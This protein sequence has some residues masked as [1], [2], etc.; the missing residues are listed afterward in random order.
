[1]VVLSAMPTQSRQLAAIMFTDIVGYTALMQQNEEKAIQ[2]RE[3][4]RRI[5]NSITEKHKGRILQYY[6]DGTLSIFDSAID[7]VKCGI[8]LQLGFQED[9]VIPVRIGI[10]TGDIIFSEEEIIGDGVNIASRIESL[11]VPGS[12][13]ISDKVYD[14]IKNQVSI[15]TSMLSA[16]K[17]KNVEKPV[18]VY[19]ISNVGLVVPSPDDIEGKVSAESTSIFEKEIPLRKKGQSKIL[20][21]IFVVIAIVMVIITYQKFGDKKNRDEDNLDKSIAVLPIKSL[22]D[23]PEKQYLAD[24]VMDAITTHLAKIRELR[25]IA[26]TSLERYKDQAKDVRDIGQELNVNFL[27]EG[28]FQ[29]YGDDAMLTVQLINTNDGSHIWSNEYE[30]EWKDIFAVQSEVAQAIAKKIKVIITPGIKQEIESI[31]TSDL[32]AYDYYLRGNEYLQ[33]SYDQQDYRYAIQMYQRATEID[34]KFTLA[35]VGLAAASRFIY[36][37]YYDRSEEQLLRIKKY[38]DKAL[39]LSPQSKEVLLEEGKYHYHCKRD[40]PKALQI[41]EKLESEYPNDDELYAWIGYVYRRMGEFRKSL[42]YHDHAI[43]LNP[44]NWEYWLNAGIT[45]VVLREY[46]NAEKYIKKAI[47]LNPSAYRPYMDLLNLYSVTGDVKKAKDFLKNNQEY[48]DHPVIKHKRSDIDILDGNYE[49]AIQ[50]TE[51]LSDDEIK[52]LDF[53]RSKHLQL[54]LIHHMMSNEKMAVKHFE[55]ERIFLE[56]KIKELNNDSRLYSS[57]GIAY[58]GLGNKSK[59]IEA[60]KKAIEILGLN[61]DALW[62]FY[63]EMDMAKI[64]LMVGEYDGVLSRIENLLDQSGYI[65]VEL[66]KIDPFWNPVREMDRFKEIISNPKYQID[67]SDN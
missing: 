8:E 33:R 19:A 65:S 17:L 10:H 11:A 63:T 54:G 35:W 12:V 43:L 61:T 46:N 24:G 49:E 36:W 9:P 59:A 51:S 48:N 1:M 22:S 28:S 64:L 38:L 3:K 7:A 50:I 4:H 25:V 29:M 47:D 13:F 6:G 56:E 57:L 27:L 16:F 26:R 42:E 37:M 60:G 15:E 66:L 62:G 67:L 55:A 45:L 41:L 5:F 18:Q 40:Y 14:E 2:A 23:D 31:P 39:T 58:A 20:Y 32:T 44:S 52:A 53:Y 21:T 30:R 34:P